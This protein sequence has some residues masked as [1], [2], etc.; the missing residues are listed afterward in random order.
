MF[1]YV[2]FCQTYRKL[3]TNFFLL[4]NQTGP[5]Y[6]LRSRRPPRLPR[7]RLP[8][9][10]FLA[11]AA[12]SSSSSRPA[13]SPSSSLRTR[14]LCELDLVGAVAPPAGGGPKE[15]PVLRRHGGSL[16]FVWSSGRLP[17][18]NKCQS[19]NPCFGVSVHAIRNRIWL[20]SRI[21]KANSM[22]I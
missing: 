7:G 4:P 20:L 5:L 13:P 12:P 21:P 18:R 11:A 8:L 16:C 10:V 3:F 17:C 1:G 22:A 14:L 15:N 6:S 9:L 2:W 19:C